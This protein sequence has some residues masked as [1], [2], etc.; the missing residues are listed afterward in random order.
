M[1]KLVGLQFRLQ[2]KQG[3]KNKATYALSRVGY[4]FATQVV[5]SGTSLDTRDFEFL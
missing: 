1:V 5:S 2:Y 3:P 4:S